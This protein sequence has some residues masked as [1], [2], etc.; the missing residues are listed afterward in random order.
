MGFTRYSV[1]Q[2]LT[3]SNNNIATAMNILLSE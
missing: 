2:A 3:A 1:L